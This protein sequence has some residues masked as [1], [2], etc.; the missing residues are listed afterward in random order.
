MKIA[1]RSVTTIVAMSAA[2]VLVFA[3]PG[4]AAPIP[5]F[6]DWE[7]GG[8]G[9]GSSPSTYGDWYALS[10]GGGLA[11]T[12]QITNSSPIG[13]S[14]NLAWD[15]TS[16]PLEG[17][18]SGSLWAYDIDSPQGT[19]GYR[20]TAKLH[21]FDD[22]SNGAAGTGV[23][24]DS[25]I[26]LSNLGSVW[27][28]S[29]VYISVK[30]G[31]WRL[32]ASGLVSGGGQSDIQTIV[33]GV[34]DEVVTGIIEVDMVNNFTTASIVHSGGTDTADGFNFPA[35]NGNAISRLTLQ[36]LKTGLSVDDIS[37]TVIPEP[38]TLLLTGLGSIGLLAF[39]RQRRQRK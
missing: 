17:A 38:H 33:S 30:N 26:G 10:W 39:V 29:G 23:G 2:L 16:K 14:G 35:S 11:D 3:A 18:G 12:T 19:L 9:D 13:G 32:D 37:I 7:T 21:A 24:N 1:N 8:G 6:E 25:G 31:E 15:S 27:N 5:F 22:T 4:V 28:D 20:L 34:T 36:S